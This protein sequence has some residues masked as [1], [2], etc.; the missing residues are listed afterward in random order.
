MLND[1]DYGPNPFFYASRNDTLLGI[2]E[3]QDL[4][5][6]LKKET[7]KNENSK[8]R[9]ELIEFS[10]QLNTFSNPILIKGYR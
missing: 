5:T 8:Q 1:I 7:Q 3:P 6:Y 2:I 4:L 10:K 9:Q